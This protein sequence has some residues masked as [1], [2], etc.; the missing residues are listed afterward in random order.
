MPSLAVSQPSSSARASTSADRWV[1]ITRRAASR[2]ACRCKL[3]TSRWNRILP[4]LLQGDQ[5]GG[6]AV[7]QHVAV[8]AGGVQQNARWEA[9]AA[10]EG[11]TRA[12]EPHLD[13][14]LVTP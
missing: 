3:A 13:R 6:A 5:G 7:Q 10:A 1:R 12:D 11:I 9:A 2:P 4:L 8:V 14:V